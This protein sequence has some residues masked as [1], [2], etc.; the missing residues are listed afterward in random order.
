MCSILDQIVVFKLEHIMFQGQRKR[1]ECAIIRGDAK[2]WGGGGGRYGNLPLEVP[3][4][5]QLY[6]AQFTIMID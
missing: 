6:N 5:V 1:A 2:F 3:Q 4:I